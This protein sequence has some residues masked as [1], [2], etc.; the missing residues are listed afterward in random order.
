MLDDL[1]AAQQRVDDWQSVIEQRAVQAR[2]LSRR[3]AQVQATA[4]SRDGLIEVTVASSG[5][6]TGLRLDERVREQ[7]AAGIA[8]QILVV[9]RAAHAQLA[10]RVTRATA[11][12][13]GVDSATGRA[14]VDSLTARLAVP[15][16]PDARA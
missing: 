1:D 5:V 9:M 10:E 8:E 6:V 3:L 16:G 14:I 12:T 11:E 15:D 2:V 7:P 13:V 4:R